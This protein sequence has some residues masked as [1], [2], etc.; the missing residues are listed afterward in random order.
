[1]ILANQIMLY[2]TQ[3][4]LVINFTLKNVYLNYRPLDF[5][6]NTLNN[7]S[8]LINELFAN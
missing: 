7:L 2:K 8:M 5:V 6:K 1:M 4:K 3:A